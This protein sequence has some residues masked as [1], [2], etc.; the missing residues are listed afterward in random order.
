MA[1]RLYAP[2]GTRMSLG[3]Y[4]RV[5]RAFVE[6][7]KERGQ[8]GEEVTN[9]EENGIEHVKEDARLLQLRRDLKAR[10]YL[11]TFHL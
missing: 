6:G 7:F 3:D 10:V 8:A 5:V 2:L 1:A 4:V 9:E 11:P